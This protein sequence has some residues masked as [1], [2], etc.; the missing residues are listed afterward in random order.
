MW[1]GIPRLHTEQTFEG[2]TRRSLE[3]AIDSPMLSTVPLQLRWSD[4]LL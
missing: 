1:N 2:A 3:D 4:Y